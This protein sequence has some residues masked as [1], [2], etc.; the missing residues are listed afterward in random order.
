MRNNDQQFDF[1]MPV[2]EGSDAVC[3]I[4]DLEAETEYIFVV[5]AF[6]GDDEGEYSDEIHVETPED[7]DSV[8]Q[9]SKDAAIGDLPWPPIPLSSE[10]YQEEGDYLVLNIEDQTTAEDTSPAATHWQI[11][12]TRSEQCVLDLISN[13][14]LSRL[15]VS[16]IPFE[17]GITYY[18]R[19]RFFDTHGRVSDW[20]DTSFFTSESMPVEPDER[21]SPT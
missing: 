2:Y 4:D 3:T 11:Y 1:S 9:Q 14:M 12:D 18:W 8:D 7:K 17:A 21:I 6:D 10:F 13:R 19:A 16:D 20:S 5:Q 15:K